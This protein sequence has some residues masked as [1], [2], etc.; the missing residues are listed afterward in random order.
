MDFFKLSTIA[1]NLLSTNI[2]MVIMSIMSMSFKIRTLPCV[3]SILII[4]LP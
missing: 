2:V 4:D 3:A 1:E